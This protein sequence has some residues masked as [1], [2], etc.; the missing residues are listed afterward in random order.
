MY[1]ELQS[2]RIGDAIRRDMGVQNPDLLA[3][4]KRGSWDHA[5]KT[6]RGFDIIERTVELLSK[7]FSR[8]KNSKEAYVTEEYTNN[9]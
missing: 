3:P 8:Q 7:I 9:K 4:R 2:K 6:R 5:H 1:L